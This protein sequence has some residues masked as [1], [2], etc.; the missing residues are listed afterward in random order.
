MSSE[1]VYDLLCPVLE[2]KAPTTRLFSL[3]DRVPFCVFIFSRK[4]NKT[5]KKPHP[6][7]NFKRGN[8]SLK[9]AEITASGDCRHWETLGRRAT[10]CPPGSKLGNAA[11]LLLRFSTQPSPGPFASSCPAR[12]GAGLEETWPFETNPTSLEEII[13][14]T[15][16]APRLP[17]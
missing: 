11:R 15:E 13:P 8:Q 9:K 2:N 5:T 14:A 1:N 10:W 12:R 4:Q 7:L 17:R 3:N 6:V 16:E